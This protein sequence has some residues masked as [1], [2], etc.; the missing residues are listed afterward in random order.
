MSIL[1]IF[2]II[3]TILF[4]LKGYNQIISLVN[5]IIKKINKCY[6]QNL[7]NKK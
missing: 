6:N 1:I 7:E 4:K 3:L 5:E 2:T